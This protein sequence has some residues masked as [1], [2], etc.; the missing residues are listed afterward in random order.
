MA[1]ALKI[2][3]LY[4]AFGKDIKNT[5]KDFG[6]SIL[7]EYK[8]KTILFDSGTNADLLEKNATAL[9]VDL[10]DVDF[11]VA[12]HAHADHTGGFHY[13]KRINPNVKIYYPDDFFGAGA[14]LTFDVAGKD[15]KVVKDLAIEQQYFSGETTKAHLVGNGVHYKSVIYVKEH[16]EIFPGINLI[17]TRSPNIGYFTKYPG[18]DL[19]GNLVE[20]DK[21]NFLG[22]PELS[23]SISTHKGEILF[24]GCS[25]STVEAIVREAR[26]VLNKKTYQ[27]IGG[28][29]LLPYDA[30]TIEGIATRLKTIL[31]VERVAPAHCTGHLAFKILREVYG[32]DYQ[33]FGLGSELIIK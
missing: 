21:A 18:V 11:A 1:E 25:H 32:D 22:L 3:N 16:R 31:H 5:Q 6:L 8:G 7:I 33:F 19:H 2:T 30:D 20:S 13:L 28:Y 4:D 17:V 24:V 27:L 12:S 9:K 14:P 26:D 10:A 29:H 23:L 15:P